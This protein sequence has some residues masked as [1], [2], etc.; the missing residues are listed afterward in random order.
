MLTQSP[1]RNHLTEFEKPQ[2]RSS[3]EA[4][5]AVIIALRICF[6]RNRNSVSGKTSFRCSLAI[7]LRM[8]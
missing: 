8:S 2:K 7:C 1:L 5:E 4:T 3:S 6:E